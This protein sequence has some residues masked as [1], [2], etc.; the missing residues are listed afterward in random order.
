MLRALSMMSPDE[1]ASPADRKLLRKLTDDDGD[2]KSYRGGTAHWARWFGTIGN[3]QR[4]RYPGRVP[5]EIRIP[6]Q[7]E[8]SA[9][10][11]GLYPWL[12]GRTL[13]ACGPIFGREVISGGLWHIDPWEHRKLGRVGD[14]GIYISGV[15]G[16]GKSAAAKSLVLRHGA[17]GRPFV[18]PADL[19]GEWAPVVDAVGGLTLR[20]GPGMPQRLN[21]LARPA[22]PS[23][24]DERVWWLVVRSH[25]QELLE[26]LVTTLLK[27]QRQL[28]PVEETSIELALTEATNY[29]AVSGN[30]DRLRPI[31]L[32]PVVE[33]LRNPSP[34]MAEE[35]GMPVDQLREE[36]RDVAL[37]LRKLTEGALQGIV[38]ATEQNHLIDPSRTATV[39]DISRVQSSDV[40]V[41][42]V[43]ACTQSVIE[44][45]FLYRVQQWWNVYDELWRL[46]RFPALLTRLNGGQRRSRGSGAG[47]I[48]L[49][50]RVTDA[51][52]GGPDAQRVASDL[53]SDCATKIIYRQRADALPGTLEMVRLTD[54][55]AQQLPTLPRGRAV[56][57][58]DGEPYLVDHLLPPQMPGAP[59][60]GEY[61]NEWDCIET[62]QAL[63]DDYRTLADKSAEELY[64]GTAA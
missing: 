38:D 63:S 25:W 49:S 24:Q 12:A 27:G 42:L 54:M 43:M 50:H 23:G 33:L 31:S 51:L 14:S 55:V 8:S 34:W 4:G 46:M 18:V 32:H 37:T 47:T 26:G 59:R 21:A 29:H 48:L 45:A 35:I 53:I 22:T 41:A 60:P 40:A 10:V 13:P 7:T 19:R 9:A 58:V 6:R 2:P 64:E 3:G 61:R 20:L 15:I 16:S 5:W 39:I 44:L 11:R 52:L 57:V 28:R 30:L 17:F 1:A 56:H 36:I 62:D